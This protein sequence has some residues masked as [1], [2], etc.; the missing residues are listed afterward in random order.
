M[1]DGSDNTAVQIKLLVTS[2]NIIAVPACTDIA[3]SRMKH[4]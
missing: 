1:G 2:L 3:I 4:S